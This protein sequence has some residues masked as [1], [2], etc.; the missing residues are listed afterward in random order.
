MTWRVTGVIGH[1][2]DEGVFFLAT[3]VSPLVV[4]IGGPVLQ[5]N[6]VLVPIHVVGLARVPFCILNG[7]GA[8]EPIHTNEYSVSTSFPP[9]QIPK[10]AAYVIAKVK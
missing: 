10:S 2:T 6:T 1:L 3:H 5:H 7:T 9:I 4:A 8:L